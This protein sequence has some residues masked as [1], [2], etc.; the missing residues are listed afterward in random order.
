[1]AGFGGVPPGAPPAPGGG[2]AGLLDGLLP[3]DAR[4]GCESATRKFGRRRASVRDRANQVWA[5]EA[6]GPTRAHR[7]WPLRL[8]FPPMSTR[9]RTVWLVCL[10]AEKRFSL[11]FEVGGKV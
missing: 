11:F 4:T 10:P 5:E 2:L 3:A 9:A 1:M 7:S 8:P 6:I